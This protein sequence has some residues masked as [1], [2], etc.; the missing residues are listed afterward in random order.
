VA[1]QLSLGKERKSSSHIARE[2]N[3]EKIAQ[4]CGFFPLTDADWQN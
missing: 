2:Q 3:R 1:I 4:A